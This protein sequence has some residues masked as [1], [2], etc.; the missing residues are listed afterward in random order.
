MAMLQRDPHLGFPAHDGAATKTIYL[1]DDD[2]IEMKTTWRKVY[3]KIEL[4]PSAKRIEE[5]KRREAVRYR[6]PR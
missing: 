4:K 1:S 2:V 3:M 5:A 6:G